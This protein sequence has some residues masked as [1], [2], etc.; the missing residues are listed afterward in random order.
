MI[1]VEIKKCPKCGG[2]MTGELRLGSY[3]DLMLKKD[4]QFVGEPINTFCCTNCGY[5]E[6]FKEMRICC[7]QCC[8]LY[9]KSR[10]K[11]PQCGR[12]HED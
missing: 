5:I 9:D 6:L 11:C 4:D 1:D 7:P 8:T 10:D 3:T 2:D 12:K